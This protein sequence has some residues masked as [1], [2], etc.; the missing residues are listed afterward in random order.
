MTGQKARPV[1]AMSAADQSLPK[2]AYGVWGFVG[3]GTLSAISSTLQDKAK[4]PCKVDAGEATKPAKGNILQSNIHA[5][6][7][8]KGII[9][10]VE[11]K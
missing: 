1:H 2:A 8:T 5:L 3:K 11:M 7:G 4:V 9:Q 10:R 6:L